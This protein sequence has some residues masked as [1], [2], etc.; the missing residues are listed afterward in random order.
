MKRQLT[1]PLI[2]MMLKPIC[3]AMALLLIVITITSASVFFPSSAG[4]LTVLAKNKQY[5][6]TR[7]PILTPISIG[8]QQKQISPP[9]TLLNWNIYKQQKQNWADSLKEWATSADFITL[10]EAKLS[11]EL[12]QF[13]VQNK[14][15]YLHNY[16]FKYNDFI[17][18]VNTLSK[19][20][21]LAVCASTYQEPWIRV[22][23]TGIASSYPIRGSKQTLLLI[24][25]HGVNFTLTEQP[26]REQLSPYLAL[27]KQHIGPVIFSGDFNTWSDARLLA[28]EQSLIKSGLSEAL[29]DDDKR[30]TMFGLPLDHIYF[31]GLKVIETKSLTTD[32][33]DH[34]PQLVTFDIIKPVIVL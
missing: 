13:S 9:F 5:Y 31:R 1:F 14:L 6:Q 11:P 12:I 2:S 33:S 30:I 32:A 25:L 8:I 21:P 15:S 16:A 26:L 20:P 23:K 22:P 27:I 18:G 28:V 7:C 10:Q 29:F 19:V 24:N 17:Y 34:N 4:Q 3:I